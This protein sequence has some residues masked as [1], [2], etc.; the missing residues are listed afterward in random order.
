M[1]AMTGSRVRHGPGPGLQRRT[2]YDR[3]LVL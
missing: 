1:E 2:N 3:G